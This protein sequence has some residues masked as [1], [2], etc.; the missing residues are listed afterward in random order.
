MR[1]FVT[2]EKRIDRWGHVIA[3][4]E[5]EVASIMG[6]VAHD[7]FGQSQADTPVDSGA[8]KNSG[9]LEQSGK[10]EWTIRYTMHY[11][12]YVHEG[13][14]SMTARPFLRNAVEGVIPSMTAAFQ[15][16]EGRLA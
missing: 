2:V 15:S 12:G 14:A 16:L 5:P 4:F 11:A 7:A 1:A 13:T 9:G 10:L 3:R 6:K 8:L